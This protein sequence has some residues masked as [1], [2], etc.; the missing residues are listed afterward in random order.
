MKVGVSFGKMTMFMVAWFAQNWGAG[1]NT[2]GVVPAL[3]DNTVGGDH[4]PV[5]T[6]L[7]FE[8]AGKLGTAP[9]SQIGA[10]GVNIGLIGVLTTTKV[11]VVPLQLG[12]T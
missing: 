5:M 7:L 11:V 1:V 4:V 8:L 2:Y 6:G 9:F 3:V 12:V 10:I